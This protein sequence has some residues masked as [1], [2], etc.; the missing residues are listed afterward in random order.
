MQKSIMYRAGSFFRTSAL[1]L[2][3]I[4]SST[5]AAF[6]LDLE[7][8]RAKGLVGEVDNGYIAIPPG[9]GND[10]QALIGTVNQERRAAYSDIATKN[11]ITVDVAGKRTFEK[12]YPG[13]P[14]GTWVQMQGKWSKK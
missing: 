6:A 13:F 7:T 1:L 8:A 4:A 14:A 9:A 2:A 12:R 10:A 5:A 3:F 11:G